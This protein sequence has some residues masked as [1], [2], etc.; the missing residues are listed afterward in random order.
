MKRTISNIL[1]AEKRPRTERSKFPN[2]ISVLKYLL[3]SCLGGVLYS[4]WFAY[5]IQPLFWK[6]LQCQSEQSCTKILFIADPQIQGELAVPPPLSYLFNWDSDRYLKSTFSIVEN[7]FRP[8]ILVYLG[9]LMD[10]GSISTRAQFHGYVK[11]LSEIFD[12]RYPVV[13][14]WIPGDNDI[15]GEN[16]P[17]KHDKIEEFRTVY[18]QP[19]V[20]VFKNISFYKVSTITYSV[21]QPLEN[22]LNFKIAISHYPVIERTAYAKKVIDSIHPDIFFCAHEHKSKYVKFKRDYASKETHLLSYNDPV[23]SISFDNN[24]LYEIYVPTCSYRMGTSKIGYGAAVVE[25]NNQQLKYTVFW[26]PARF[27]YLF[28]YLLMLVILIGYTL[29]CCFIRI[30]SK[31]SNIVKTEDKQFL[32]QHT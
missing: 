30:L 1:Y 18:S 4:E 13:Q 22:D 11:R 12:S 27:P 25:K 29:L 32:L 24:W 9:D 21:P 3:A 28:F 14:V 16:E 8:D 20:I 15:G 17:I 26:S 31:L 2:Q 7:Y 10:E 19:N 5:K 23:L 6:N